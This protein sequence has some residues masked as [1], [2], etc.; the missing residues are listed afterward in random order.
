MIKKSIAKTKRQSQK[1]DF[2]P[3]KM[4]FAVATLAAVSL[5]L[6]GVMASL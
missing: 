5:A 3:T 2:E 1:V 6:L 4:G